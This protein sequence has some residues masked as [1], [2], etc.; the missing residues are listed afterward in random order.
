M[1]IDFV[2][3][4]SVLCAFVVVALLLRVV[5]AHARSYVKKRTERALKTP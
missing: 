1:N 5:E 4:L 2:P 3:S